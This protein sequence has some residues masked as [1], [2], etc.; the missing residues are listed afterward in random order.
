MTPDRWERIQELYHAAR[1]HVET[2]RPRFL[3]RACSGDA[4]LQ[5]EVEALLEQPVSTSGFVDFLGGPAPARPKGNGANVLGRRL[6]SY[7]VRSLLGV[8]GMGEVYRAHDD[9]LGRDVAIKMLPEQFAADPDRLARFDSEARMLAALNHLHIGAIYGLEHA[10]GVPAL[11][12]ELVEGETLAERLQRG[13]V[14]VRDALSMARQVADALDAAHQKGIIHRD[15]KPANIKITPAGVVKVLDFG[16]AKVADTDASPRDELSQSPTAAIGST[17]VG[18]ILGTAPYMS[19]EQARGM[20]ADTRAD[21]WAFGCVLYEMLAGRP[22][23]IGQTVAETFAAIVEREPDWT[24]LPHA[25]PAS[26]RELLRHCLQKDMTRR[27]QNIADAR[28]TIEKAQR[29][30]NRWRVAAIAAAAV[31]AVAVGTGLWW[32]APVRPADRSAWVQ[33]TTLPDSVIHPAVSPDGRM[34][35]FVRGPS[36][37][38]VPYAPGQVYVKLLP[39]GEPVQLTNDTLAKMSPVFSPDGARI[40][41][42]TVGQGF[43]WDTWTVPVLG[44]E[45][46]KWLDN[47]SGL[48]WAGAGQV[49]FSEIR[50]GIHMGIVATDENRNGLRELYLPAH[51]QGMAHLSY[52]SPDRKW[53]LLA[54]MDQNHSWT[55]CRVIPMDGASDGRLVG[56][57][58]AGCTFGAW[59]PN[60]QWIY[61]TSNAGGANH[62][63]RQRFPD[64][65][66]EQL[67]SGPTEEEGIAMAA[68]GRSFVTAVALR[69]R[70]LWFHSGNDERQISLEGNAVDAKFASDGKRLV[71]KVV[72][73]LGTYPLPGDLRVANLDTGRSDG[74]T[75]GFRVIDYDLSADGQ[76]VVLEAESDGTSRL[77]LARI[78]GKLPPQ[79]IPNVE[80]RQPRF[81]PAGEILF[82]RPEGAAT[83]VY[84]VRPDGTGLRKVIEQPIPLLGAVSP[85]GR[86]LEAW[87]A[88]PGNETSAFQLFPLSGGSP[89]SIAAFIGWKWAPRGDAVSISGGPVP[90]GRSYVIPLRAGEVSPPIPAGGLRS[91]QDVAQLPGARKVDAVVVPG[92]SPDDY[93][94]YRTTTQRNL[95]RIPIP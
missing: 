41:Y 81:G 34:V 1:A 77:W 26:V 24:G 51:A 28:V 8:G 84:A 93:A 29:G 54:E 27:L 23:F 88:S 38:V 62:V 11:V 53:L 37:A 44:G 67:T 94:F 55:P 22:A 86:F 15:L 10:D 59:S 31:A 75:L 66:P 56:P 49:S 58:G 3:A 14:S 19:P 46:R 4:A 2:E 12:L 30:W 82:R 42:T 39:D 43:G 70:S 60:G 40:A 21:I 36:S 25:T 17:R 79:Q 61:L 71:Y 69:N 76:Q 5:R 78:D 16:L 74:L 50:K 18:V 87:T 45:P 72:S 20:S 68:D 35:A 32:P 80:G 33:L 85:D 73:S 91:E 9:K 47:A 13:P 57:P 6:G 48:A 83:F 90:E 95:Y 52:A 65:Q 63:W 64:G 7:H 92:A 89:V